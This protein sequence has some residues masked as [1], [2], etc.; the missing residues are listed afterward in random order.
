MCLCGFQSGAVFVRMA[1]QLEDGTLDSSLMLINGELL[2]CIGCITDY[3]SCWT[4]RINWGRE[5]R[6]HLSEFLGGR[7][8]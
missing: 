6:A 5:N 4:V 8:R 7:R 2:D 1:V 3:V